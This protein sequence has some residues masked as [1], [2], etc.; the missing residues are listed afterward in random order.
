MAKRG[1]PKK[2]IDK[3]NFEKLCGMQCTLKEIAGFFDCSEDTI[4]RWCKRTY[5]NTF[6]DTFKNHS[7][8]GLISLRRN[9]FKL[10]ERSAA[11][12]IFLGKQYLHQSDK[13]E[14]ETSVITD[15]TRC[16]INNLIDELKHLK[17]LVKYEDEYKRKLYE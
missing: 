6:A 8:A 10:A 7:A 2:E 3:N 17:E 13:I 11:M 4:E 5:K 16:E 1:R 9:Q 14:M 12:A 15:A